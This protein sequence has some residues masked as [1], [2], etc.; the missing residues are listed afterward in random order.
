MRV[1]RLVLGTTLLF[2]AQQASARVVVVPFDVS[3]VQGSGGLGADAGQALA[4]I[5]SNEIERHGLEPERQ[6]VVRGALVQAG[7][8]N[9]GLR[10]PIGR[11]R[12]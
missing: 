2:G 7:A 5:V 6:L 4:R 9:A 12:V 8:A 11:A 10:G 3:T 1:V